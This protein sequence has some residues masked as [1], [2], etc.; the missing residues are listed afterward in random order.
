M[1]NKVMLWLVI[2][3][4]FVMFG[5]TK[6]EI[7]SSCEEMIVKVSSWEKVENISTIYSFNEDYTGTALLNSLNYSTS[8]SI[9]GDNL[10]INYVIDELNYSKS[11]TLSC[12]LKTQTFT[13]SDSAG[14]ATFVKKGTQIFK[15][16]SGNKAESLKGVWHDDDT[17]IAYLLTDA[18]NSGDGFY[19]DED[20]TFYILAH[21]DWKSTN[22]EL[23]IQNQSTGKETTY[24]YE[25]KDE[26]LSLYY[27]NKLVGTYKHVK[28]GYTI[29][30]AS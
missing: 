8:W 16:L 30:E 7:Y 5:C 12:D 3:I 11:Y 27:D 2:I 21:Y 6:K 23:I 14:T 24:K 29:N 15:K 18:K 17:G 20:K 4:C 9:S 22:T 26:I 1:K 13:I 28:D 10:K 19:K 25:I